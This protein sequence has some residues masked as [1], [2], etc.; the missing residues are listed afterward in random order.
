MEL[1]QSLERKGAQSGMCGK[2]KLLCVSPAQ[3]ERRECVSKDK[4][5]DSPREL[6]A[7]QG[8]CLEVI[9]QEGTPGL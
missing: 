5:Q 7:I 4:F 8:I 6:S 2:T 9:V 1:K 3:L